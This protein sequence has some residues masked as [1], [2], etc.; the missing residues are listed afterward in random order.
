MP[1]VG[2][3]RSTRISTSQ[4]Q[5]VR[6]IESWARFVLTATGRSSH[7]SMWR[8]VIFAAGGSLMKSAKLTSV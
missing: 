5:N 8:R 6:M 2:S 3:R 7:F 1:I 4:R